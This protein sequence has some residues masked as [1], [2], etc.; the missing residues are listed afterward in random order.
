MRTSSL[1]LLPVSKIAAT[2]FMAVDGEFPRS[3]MQLHYYLSAGARA[4]HDNI[5]K[6]RGL[7]AR[8]IAA[9]HV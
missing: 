2:S 3:G 8:T 7:R 6:P 4:P 1:S 5:F 9:S